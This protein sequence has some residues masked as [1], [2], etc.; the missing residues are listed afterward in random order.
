M[1]KNISCKTA[2]S[3]FGDIYNTDILKWYLAKSLISYVSKFD[4]TGPRGQFHQ[5]YI[6]DVYVMSL[7]SD[8]AIMWIF[9][10]ICGRLIGPIVN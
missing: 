1:G 9:P 3:F 8:F 10:V 2:H 5:L 4:N 7:S 6:T